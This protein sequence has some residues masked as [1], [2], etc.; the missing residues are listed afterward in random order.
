[1][2]IDLDRAGVFPMDD[3]D[4]QMLPSSPDIDG[5]SEVSSMP[6]AW[7]SAADRTQDDTT[8]ALDLHLAAG[9]YHSARK[10]V[11][12]QFESRYVRWLVR[13]TRGNIS[14]AARVAGVE[15]A[16]LYRLLRRLDRNRDLGTR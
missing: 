16:T 14:E 8:V 4:R 11:I 13:E 12:A 9:G 5:P 7:S 15:R 3:A 6:Q 2:G 1:M 10:S